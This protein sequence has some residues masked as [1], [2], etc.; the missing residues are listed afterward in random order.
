[1]APST[2]GNRKSPLDHDADA[3]AWAIDKDGWASRAAFAKAVGI[4]TSY[5]SEILGGTRN[6]PPHLLHKMARVLNCPVS[7]LER[8]RD[9]S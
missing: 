5:L 9:A 6:A 7:V 3:I 8:K 2:R 4:S 1:M